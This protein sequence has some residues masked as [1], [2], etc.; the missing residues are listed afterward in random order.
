MTL[1]ESRY[2]GQLWHGLGIVFLSIPAI[3]YPTLETTLIALR[4]SELC[5]AFSTR[6]YR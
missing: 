2:A 5:A 3:R 4:N 6:E 1:A